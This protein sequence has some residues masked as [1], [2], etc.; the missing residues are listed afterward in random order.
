MD[1]EHGIGQSAR[2]SIGSQ[3]RPDGPDEHALIAVA[4]DDKAADARV[5]SVSNDEAGR[6]ITE[7]G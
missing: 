6:E 3:R 4:A 5:G 7:P 1:L 2:D